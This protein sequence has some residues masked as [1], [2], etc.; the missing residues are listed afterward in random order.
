MHSPL[1]ALFS[2]APLENF[3]CALFGIMNT[4]YCSCDSYTYSLS[5]MV[6]VL[7]MFRHKRMQL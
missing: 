3:L 4:S 2:I 5:F 7:I 6:N 1:R